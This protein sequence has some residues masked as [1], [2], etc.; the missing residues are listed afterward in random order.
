M[1]CYL[2]TNILVYALFDAD[3]L[4][5]D[6]VAVMMDYENIL[7]TSSV[8]VQELIHL[9]QIGKLTGKKQSISAGSLIG[10]IRDMNMVSY[11]YRKSI[12]KH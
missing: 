6:T 12:L 11:P 3:E 8:C 9:C 2:D 4:H 5:T 10:Q 1:R 7:L